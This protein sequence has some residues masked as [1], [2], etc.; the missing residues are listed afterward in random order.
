M[1]RDIRLIKRWIY[2]YKDNYDVIVWFFVHIHVFIFFIY[3]SLFFRF[4]CFYYFFFVFSTVLSERN[5]S[6]DASFY[7]I[8]LS[9]FFLIFS[10]F[11]HFLHSIVRNKYTKKVLPLFDFNS[12]SVILLLLH[13]IIRK[14]YSCDAGDR[15]GRESYW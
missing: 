12:F 8:L 14:K 4:I 15:W 13:S 6:S 3:Y 1:K 11:T 9:N 10:F 7:F 5:Y 2:I